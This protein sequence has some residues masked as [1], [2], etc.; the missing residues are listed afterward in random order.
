MILYV[1]DI[2][3]AA[4]SKDAMEQIYKQIGEIFKV[5]EAS[6]PT[7]Y[8]GM[9]IVRDRKAKSLKLTQSAHIQRIIDEFDK[10][11]KKIAAT[12]M[13]KH[14]KLQKNDINEVDIAIRDEY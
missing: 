5:L 3:L 7:Y 9:R 6:E 1:N 10:D 14:V 11:S 8:L 13:D 2:Q 12:P 4:P